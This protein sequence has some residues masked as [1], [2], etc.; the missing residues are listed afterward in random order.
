MGSITH[1]RSVLRNQGI[2]QLT[3][4]GTPCMCVCVCVRMCAYVCVCAC[5][6]V[7]DFVWREVGRGRVEGYVF[8][9]VRVWICNV[10]SFVCVLML[11]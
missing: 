8:M 4:G 2:N 7:C 1:Y 6:H 3:C 5:T 9:H 10:P 11:L